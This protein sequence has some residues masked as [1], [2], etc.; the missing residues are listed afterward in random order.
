MKLDVE[1]SPPANDSDMQPADFVSRQKNTDTYSISVKIFIYEFLSTEF[2]SSY[3]QNHHLDPKFD[4]LSAV[5]F[6]K[7]CYYGVLTLSIKKIIEWTRQIHGHGAAK[8]TPCPMKEF[9]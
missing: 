8:E 1:V 4:F 9:S 3:R 6:W 7:Q 2:R 5:R